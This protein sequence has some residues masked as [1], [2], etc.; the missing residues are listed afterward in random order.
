MATPEVEQTI[1]NYKKDNPGIFSWEIRDRLIKDG[2]CDRNTVPSVSSISRVLRCKSKGDGD[3]DSDKSSPDKH[4]I[5]GILGEKIL[6]VE[7]D[8]EDEEED[9][10]KTPYFSL[11]ITA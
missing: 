4:S 11:A 10:G 5:E 8:Y 6:D 2:L 7:E 1:D 9:P 3:D